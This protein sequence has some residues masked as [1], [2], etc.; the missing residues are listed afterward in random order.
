MKRVLFDTNVILDIFLKRSPHVDA[1][2]AAFSLAATNRVVGFV[3]GHA[4][5]T[6][7]YVFER[8]V[9][10]KKMRAALSE[11]LSVLTVAAVDDAAIRQA[12][13][14]PIGD[15]EDAVTE[16][17][18]QR[19]NVSTIVTRNVVDFARSRIPALP[20]DAFIASF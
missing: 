2:A 11:A 9:G 15:F 3:A 12:L 8:E 10:P 19:A 6:I 17:A 4:V 1:S 20:P 18:A 5:T 7:A 13:K 14:S 16:I